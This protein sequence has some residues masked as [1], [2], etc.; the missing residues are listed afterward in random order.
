MEFGQIYKLIAPAMWH[1]RR[2]KMEIDTEM[3][4]RIDNCIECLKN[5][6]KHEEPC[7][8]YETCESRLIEMLEILSD[9]IEK[10][11]Y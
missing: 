7:P 4:N 5:Y 11:L 6:I 3:K 2:N 1:T 9:R 8:C 10:G